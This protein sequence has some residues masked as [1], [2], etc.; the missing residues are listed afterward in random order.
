MILVVSLLD[1]CRGDHAIVSSHT[2]SQRFPSS[3]RC[4]LLNLSQSSL[5]SYEVLASVVDLSRRVKHIPKNRRKKLEF[6]L[7]SFSLSI[8]IH[9]KLL[10]NNSSNKGNPKSDQKSIE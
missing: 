9:A 7:K 3:G 2:R 4:I 10:Q 1:P 6:E 8:E 5:P